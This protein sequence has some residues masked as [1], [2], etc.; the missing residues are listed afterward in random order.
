VI[1]YIVVFDRSPR[2]RY[3]AFHDEFVTHPQI[4]RWWH[5]LK[6]CYII[7]SD[8]SA[9]ELSR[10]YRAVAGKHGIPRNVLVMRVDL[11]SRQGWLPPKAWEW[12]Q[13]NTPE[14][15]GW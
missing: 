2:G 10:H 8:L 5:Y 13:R 11:R 3:M 7:G 15:D 1:F 4:Y 9:A 6:S 14:Q 12:I